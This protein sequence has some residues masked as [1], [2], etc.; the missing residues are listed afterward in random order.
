MLGLGRIRPRGLADLLGYAA[1]VEQ[2]VC[3]LKDG[4]FLAAWVYAGPDLDSASPEELAVLSSQIN[5]ALVGLGNGWMLHVDAIRCPST[6]Y[7]EAGAFPD[8]TTQLIDAERRQQYTAE[9]THY[10]SRH[11]LALTYR[12]PADVETRLSALFFEGKRAQRQGWE[13]LLE[14]FRKTIAA[15]EDA[16]SA[17]LA[18]RRLDS[19]ALLTYLHTCITG[20][21]HLVQ[22]PRIPM[23]L[24]GVLASQDITGG[25][26]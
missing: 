15:V 7:P 12:T 8:A 23:Y 3:L 14:I 16:L 21:R 18:L 2:G 9:G 13:H 11:Y 24:D 20:L 10:E 6:G 4:A 26:Q 5:G 25:F 22:M 19:A 1:L 17:R